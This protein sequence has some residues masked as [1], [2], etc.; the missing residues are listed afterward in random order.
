MR[1]KLFLC[2][3]LILVLGSAASAQS[4]FLVL[5]AFGNGTD[6]GGVWDVPAFD[7]QG[8]LYGTT[9]G[10]G[11]YMYGTVWELSPTL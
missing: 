6:G 9:S 5:H 8:N 2:L 4:K 10:G 3:V 11:L 7:S 1:Y